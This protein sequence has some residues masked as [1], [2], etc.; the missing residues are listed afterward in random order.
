MVLQWRNMRLYS[1]KIVPPLGIWYRSSTLPH[2][3]RC[4][5][6]SS[7]IS[8]PVLILL[9]FRQLLLRNG[10]VWVNVCFVWKVVWIEYTCGWTWVSEDKSTQPI[11]AY[12]RCK[13]WMCRK[14]SKWSEQLT[15]VLRTFFGALIHLNFI[16]LI[17]ICF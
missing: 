11:S 12:I 2:V 10:K 1:R 6:S 3:S 5:A 16:I 15:I 9:T 13:H 8:V 17:L 7:A 14:V 4:F